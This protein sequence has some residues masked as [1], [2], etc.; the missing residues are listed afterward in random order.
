MKQ[1]A[2][3]IDG[4][5]SVADFAKINDRVEITATLKPGSVSSASIFLDFDGNVN[6]GAP[7]NVIELVKNLLVY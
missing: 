7:Q 5:W 2:S 4:N 1:T 6:F 3:S